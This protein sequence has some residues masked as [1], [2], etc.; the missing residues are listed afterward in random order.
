MKKGSY[1]QEQARKVPFLVD[2]CFA[3]NT[4]ITFLI[5]FSFT[6]HNIASTIMQCGYRQGT[7]VYSGVRCTKFINCIHDTGKW[8]FVAQTGKMHSP[9][10]FH[11]HEPEIKLW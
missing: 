3:Y 2:N 1:L 7:K 5:A 4:T 9:V 10:V 6:T 11:A 8:T